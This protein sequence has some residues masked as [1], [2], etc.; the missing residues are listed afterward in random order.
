MVAFEHSKRAEVLTKCEIGSVCLQLCRAYRNA[1]T[2]RS[3]ILRDDRPPV[4]RGSSPSDRYRRTRDR[5][6]SRERRRRS[7][8]RERD[9]R[10]REKRHSGEREIKK[11]PVDENVAG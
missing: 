9:A 4:M 11:E 1:P 2:D 8:S 5:S 3:E 10:R 7:R 6:R